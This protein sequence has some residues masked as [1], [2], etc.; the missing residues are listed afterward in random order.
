[1]PPIQHCGCT[2]CSEVH[3]TAF[4]TTAAVK[5]EHFQWLKGEELLSHLESLPGGIRLL[6][7]HCGFQR[8]KT[9]A[10]SATLELKVASAHCCVSR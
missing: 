9:K 6:C 4:N 10:N 3:S 7:S 8:I 5:V 2:A 1:M